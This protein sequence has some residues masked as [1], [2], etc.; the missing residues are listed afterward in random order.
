MMG[1][2]PIARLPF[3]TAAFESLC[4]QSASAAGQATLGPRRLAQLAAP[5]NWAQRSFI[6][7][8]NG[9]WLKLSGVVLQLVANRRQ[10]KNVLVSMELP[11]ITV[12]INSLFSFAI[13][14]CPEILILPSKNLVIKIGSSLHCMF[15]VRGPLT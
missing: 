14:F 2:F 15:L 4:R 11:K 13:H 7:N 1:V 9:Q 5:H 6:N 10:V 3:V 8:E 12:W